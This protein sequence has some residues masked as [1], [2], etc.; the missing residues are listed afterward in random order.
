M[1]LDENQTMPDGLRLGSIGRPPLG[2]GPEA[3]TRLNDMI[4]ELAVEHDWRHLVVR[5]HP[6]TWR[7]VMPY[8]NYNLSFPKPGIPME[9]DR[10]VF[11][12]TDRIEV[13]Y[14]DVVQHPY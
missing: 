9:M 7:Q 10:G 8:L 12:D 13:A 11:A 3:A 4:R 5:M 1:P 6:S 2:W 14:R